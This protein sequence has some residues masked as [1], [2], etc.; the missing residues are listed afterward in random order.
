MILTW[1][2][3]WQCGI[4]TGMVLAVWPNIL[5]EGGHEDPKEFYICFCFEDREFP[6]NRETAEQIVHLGTRSVMKIKKTGFH[7]L[8][9]LVL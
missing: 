7:T 9:I 4:T 1:M 8:K 6:R 3:V 5:R 2:F